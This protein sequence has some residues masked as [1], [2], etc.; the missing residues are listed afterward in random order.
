MI[1]LLIAPKH[2]RRA[3]TL[4]ELLVV[5]AIV[6]MLV[7][8]LLP[9][10]QAA[11]EAARRSQCVNNL[12]QIGLGLHNH[13][14]VRRTFPSA[15][16]A[17]GGGLMGAADANG[18]AGPGWTFLFRILPYM[19]GSTLQQ[20]FDM[21]RPCWDSVNATAAKTVVPT[22]L[23][24]SVSNTNPTYT[25]KDGNGAALAEFAHGHYVG[26]AG[27][28]DL[29]NDPRTN[30][31]SV[32]D[33]PLFR[34]SQVRLRD[35]KD[36]ASHTIFVGEHTPLRSNSTWVGIVPG[37]VTCPTPQFAFAGCDLAAPQI[38]VHSGPGANENPPLIHT[39]N[40][41]LGYVD[42]MM[43]EHAGGCNVLFGDAS[44]RFVSGTINPVAWAAMS[45]RA[46]GEIVELS[47]SE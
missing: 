22:Y 12:K 21:K 46:A 34:N 38:N 5:I 1:Q 45:T 31:A 17:T 19:E 33:G 23:C 11:R 30:L 26:N 41:Y 24:P 15:Y 8:L 20:S 35:I 6:G 25:V 4:I 27:R 32:A 47:E 10:V 37:S 13:H 3:F 2:S 36:G 14:D 28:N 29:W 44:V 7:G 16:Q 42:E 39:P 40:D 9:A 43:S 18:D